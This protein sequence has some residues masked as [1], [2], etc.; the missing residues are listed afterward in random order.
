MAPRQYGQRQARVNYSGNG[1]GIMS[2]PQIGRINFIG[3]SSNLGI[4]KIM[5]SPTVKGGMRMSVWMHP[6][7]RSLEINADVYIT[8]HALQPPHRHLLGSVASRNRDQHNQSGLERHPE[9]LM[10]AYFSLS[11]KNSLLIFTH[12]GLSTIS[13]DFPSIVNSS[14]YK[15]K[16][17]VPLKNYSSGL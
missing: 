11:A 14:F 10:G 7:M 2:K 15:L 6:C 3:Q 4:S 13:K 9:L 8:S 16:L 17:S 5:L 12:L 1:M